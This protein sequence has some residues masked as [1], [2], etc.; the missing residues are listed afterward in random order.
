MLRLH[1]VA[2]F[3]DGHY[4][5]VGIR[6]VVVDDH[7]MFAEAIAARLAAVAGIEVAGIACDAAR[8]P[9]HPQRATRRDHARRQSW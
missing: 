1:D 4:R 9:S 7:A 8:A 3:G 6:V 5:S 2:L